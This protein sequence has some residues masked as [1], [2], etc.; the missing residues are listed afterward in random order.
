MRAAVPPLR[1]RPTLTMMDMGMMDHSAHGG[2][3]S[4]PMDA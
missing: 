3:S 2:G 1:E 4:M